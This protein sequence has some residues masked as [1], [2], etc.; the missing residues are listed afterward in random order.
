MKY[1]PIEPNLNLLQEVFSFEYTHY[2]KILEKDFNIFGNLTLLHT[3]KHI[4]A[5]GDRLEF[6]YRRLDHEHKDKVSRY[7]KFCDIDGNYFI[8]R[9]NDDYGLNVEFVG[10]NK[11]FQKKYFLNKPKNIDKKI[12]ELWKKS[13]IR[14]KGQQ[15]NNENSLF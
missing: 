15:K 8:C 10:F 3:H 9:L 14:F 12:C 11:E 2:K 7:L 1:L 6:Y 5:R 4:F 13:L